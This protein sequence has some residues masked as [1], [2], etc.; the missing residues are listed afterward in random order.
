MPE[1]PGVR[2]HERIPT[3]ATVLVTWQDTAGNDKFASVRAF[4]VS[5]AGLRLILPEPLRL[6]SWVSLQAPK[7]GLH[8]RA[9]VRH[10]RRQGAKYIIGLQFVGG[11]HWK[12][13]PAS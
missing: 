10:C 5:E 7:L 4:E 6:Q 1:N 3:T 12:Q 8:G 9:S 2:R 11:L 13:L